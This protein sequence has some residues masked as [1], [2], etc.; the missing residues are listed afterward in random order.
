MIDFFTKQEK[1]IIVFLIIGLLIG[2]GVRLFYSREEFKP[3]SKKE[4]EKIEQQIKDK[5]NKIDSLLADSH[6]KATSENLKKILIDLNKA[7]FEELILLPNVGPVLANRIIEYRKING[8]F[9]N[10][11]ELKK[12]KGIGKKKLSLIAPHIYLNYK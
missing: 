12:V 11:K 1:T 10:V 6:K 7:N 4:L 5:S 2:A 3:N 9:K 8:N